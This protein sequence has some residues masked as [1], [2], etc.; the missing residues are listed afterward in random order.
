MCLVGPISRSK[1]FKRLKACE[2]E[3][4]IKSDENEDAYD[5]VSDSVDSEYDVPDSFDDGSFHLYM[6]EFTNATAQLPFDERKNL[7]LMK[8]RNQN[9]NAMLKHAYE[10]VASWN[11]L[12]SEVR[13]LLLYYGEPPS[14]FQRGYI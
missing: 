9:H 1:L 5:S 12:E 8:V 7:L 2:F 10:S 11:E 14:P 13:M 4:G 3:L 6:N